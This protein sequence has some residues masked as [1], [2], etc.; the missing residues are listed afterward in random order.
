MVLINKKR[1]AKAKRSFHSWNNVDRMGLS[2][3]QD[4]PYVGSLPK[5]IPW[6]I[7]LL[8]KICEEQ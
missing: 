3:E 6:M 4:D 2:I 5:D 7:K 1:L 8:E